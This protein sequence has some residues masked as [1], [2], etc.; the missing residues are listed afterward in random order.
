MSYVIAHFPAVADGPEGFDLLEDRDGPEVIGTVHAS[1][2]GAALERFLGKE[3]ADLTELEPAE[4]GLSWMNP[5]D[6]AWS[7]S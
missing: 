5:Y 2:L 3:D 6:Q 4:F 7:V 1:T